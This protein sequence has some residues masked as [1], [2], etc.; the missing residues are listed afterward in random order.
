[1]PEAEKELGKYCGAPFSVCAAAKSCR[2]CNSVNKQDAIDR[3]NR[4]KTVQDE[5]KGLRRN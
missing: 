1:M 5:V 2:D 3:L 4:G